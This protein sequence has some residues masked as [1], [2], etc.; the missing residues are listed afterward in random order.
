MY[1]CARGID[2]SPFY[3]FDF[4][5]VPT[6]W[7]LFVFHLIVE[8]TRLALSKNKLKER[9]QQMKN[10]ADISKHKPSFT[11]VDIVYVYRP[12]VTPGRQ[13]KLIRPWV[14]PFYIAQKLSPLHVKI[15]RKSDGKLIKNSVHIKVY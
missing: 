14:G 2:F 4:R 6:L 13:R 9:K 12:V 7:H 11:V 3:D 8:L 5:T 15:R 10:K 1:L